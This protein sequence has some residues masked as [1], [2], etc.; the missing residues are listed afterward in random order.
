MSHQRTSIR[1]VVLRLSTAPDTREPHFQ[2]GKSFSEWLVEWC[3]AID[4]RAAIE[5]EKEV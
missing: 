2:V 3:D 1:L 5:P 4:L